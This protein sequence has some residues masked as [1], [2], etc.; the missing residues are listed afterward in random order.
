MKKR[1]G[2]PLFFKKKKKN[3][4]NNNIIIIIMRRGVTFVFI[5][6]GRE[7][8]SLLR[9]TSPLIKL[10]IGVNSRVF[11]FH[12]LFLNHAFAMGLV[13]APNPPNWGA[14]LVEPM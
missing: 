3:L 11:F 6:D 10:K 8:G 2:C 13:W 7:S 12:T 9:G 14:G 5:L 1:C 4:N